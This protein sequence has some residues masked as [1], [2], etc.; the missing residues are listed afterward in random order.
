MF[1]DIKSVSWNSLF[2]RFCS[3]G[4]GKR[5]RL[6][7]QRMFIMAFL[8]TFLFKSMGLKIRP[9]I[10][11]NVHCQRVPLAWRHGRPLFLTASW[12]TIVDV[13]NSEVM[14][15]WL[16]LGSHAPGTEMPVHGILRLQIPRPKLS[17]THEP[18][19][20]LSAVTLLSITLFSSEIPG[21]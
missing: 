2:R 1:Y 11:E 17:R 15:K 9:L 19:C 4:G 3:N 12:G 7:P 14:S 10:Q 18:Q 8:E 20:T 6:L 16:Y 13:Y 5:G 21:H